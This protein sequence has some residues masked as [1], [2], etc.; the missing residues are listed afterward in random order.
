MPGLPIEFAETA[1]SDLASIVSWY[2]A[3]GVPAVGGRFVAEILA[4]VEDL[5]RHPGLG[6]VVPEFS[7]PFLRELIHPP[8]RIIYRHEQDMIFV[9]RIWRHERVLALN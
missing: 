3:Q 1:R 6:R 8:F 2:E 4:R 9:I 7:Q 5:G